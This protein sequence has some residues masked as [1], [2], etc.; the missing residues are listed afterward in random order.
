LEDGLFW[1]SWDDFVTRWDSIMV[2]RKCMRNDA[3]AM[4]HRK[5]SEAGQLDTALSGSSKASN[6]IRRPPRSG[7]MMLPEQPTARLDC[8]GKHGLVRRCASSH[9]MCDLCKQHQRRGSTL[10]GCPLCDYDVCEKCVA[11]APG[12]EVPKR[13]QPFMPPP[14]LGPALPARVAPSGEAQKSKPLPAAMVVRVACPGKH[15][16]LLGLVPSKGFSCNSC[17]GKMQQ[18]AAA[19]SCRICDVDICIQ[20]APG[21][22]K[23]RDQPHYAIAWSATPARSKVAQA[24]TRVKVETPR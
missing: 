20:C 9:V 18:G 4:L 21:P 1:M 12:V 17:G 23:A 16:L 10:H 3:E 2:C 15:K 5:S 19:V 24:A 22:R 7:S 13:K 11:R 8:P 14:R 6:S